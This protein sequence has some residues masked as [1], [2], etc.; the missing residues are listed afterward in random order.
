MALRPGKGGHVCHDVSGVAVLGVGGTG[1]WSP[2]G[3]PDWLL[4]RVLVSVAVA[5]WGTS[6][7]PDTPDAM[8]S[9]SNGPGWPAMA[10]TI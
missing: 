4:D 6:T 2:W 7:P 9:V 10:E 3:S 8:F 1:L 5:S